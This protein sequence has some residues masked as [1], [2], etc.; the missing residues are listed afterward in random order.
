MGRYNFTTRVSAINA[1]AQHRQV[2]VFPLYYWLYE[3]GELR[4]V[5]AIPDSAALKEI[6]TMQQLAKEGGTNIEL[7][8]A[9]L[10]DW[11]DTH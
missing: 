4:T 2:G 9:T 11:I 10:A 3:D 5:I 8:K 6:N 7:K 1:R